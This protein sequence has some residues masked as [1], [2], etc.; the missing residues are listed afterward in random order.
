MVWKPDERTWKNKFEL[1]I[2]DKFDVNQEK[3]YDGILYKH[4]SMG[5]RGPEFGDV[6]LVIAGCSQTYGEGVPEEA[7]WASRVAKS[8]ELSYVNLGVRGASVEGVVVRALAYLESYKAPKYL[9]C[10]LPNSE[11]IEFP[12]NENTKKHFKSKWQELMKSESRWNGVYSVHTL[13]RNH[14]PEK[15]MKLPYDIQDV[16]AV[17]YL[18]KLNMDY[19]RMLERLCE[20]KGVT[21][22]W[23]TWNDHIERNILNNNMD[24]ELKNFVPIVK[25]LGPIIEIDY[26][27]KTSCHLNDLEKYG[28]NFYKGMDAYR[29][30]EVSFGHWGVHSHIHTAEEFLASLK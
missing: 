14:E 13:P 3:E 23:G 1:D 25:A 24:D 17:E 11:R 7:T 10:L 5:Y 6:D 9:L 22:R 15:Y 27:K 26:A 20:A 18:D 2:Q 30:P 28:K 21:I 12:F 29:E 4:N 8:L 16:M 19:M